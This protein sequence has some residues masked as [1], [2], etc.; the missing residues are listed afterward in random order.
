[1]SHSLRTQHYRDLKRNDLLAAAESVFASK[2]FAHATMEE[3]ARKTGC[4]TGTIYL[5]FTN[6][7]ELYVTL[8]G[9][10]ARE[11]LEHV[12]AIVEATTKREEK[13]STLVRASMEYVIMHSGF[14]K[15]YMGERDR[16]GWEVK[17]EIYERVAEQHRE[18]S[19]LYERVVVEAMRAKVIKRS[20]PRKIAMVLMGLMYA[21]VREWLLSE[22]K[23]HA[24]SLERFIL[25]VFLHGVSD[26]KGTDK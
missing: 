10:K 15:I 23:M 19:E 24:P 13:L 9:S 25:D 18:I 7:E 3:I 11:Y 6:K 17:D 5:Y 26:R 21:V 4:A 22:S 16:L 8:L 20:Q 2:G 12:R 14:F 1:M